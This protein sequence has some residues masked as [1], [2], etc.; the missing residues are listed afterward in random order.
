VT[1]GL[2][3]QRNHLDLGLCLQEVYRTEPSLAA[4]GGLIPNDPELSLPLDR[5]P[6]GAE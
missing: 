2:P 3:A 1:G 6:R 4:G 5:E